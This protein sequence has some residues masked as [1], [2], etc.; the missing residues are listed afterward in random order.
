MLK[1]TK[2]V[3]SVNETVWDILTLFGEDP[4]PPARL[5]GCKIKT[6]PCQKGTQQAWPWLY[7]FIS[8]ITMRARQVRECGV[9]HLQ[10]AVEKLRLK[11]P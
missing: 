2:A 8:Q 5:I 9:V 3:S 10:R 7:Y 4:F 11:Y 1:D 6:H